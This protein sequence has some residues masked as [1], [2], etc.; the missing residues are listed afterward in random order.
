MNANVWDV[1]KPIEHLIRS[2]AAVDLEA[3]ADPSVAIDEL[4]GLGVPA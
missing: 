1:A 4:A 3:L 2:R